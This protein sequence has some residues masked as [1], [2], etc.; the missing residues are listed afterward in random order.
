MYEEGNGGWRKVER[1]NKR[2]GGPSRWHIAGSGVGRF[3]GLTTSF[4]ITEFNDNWKAK[5]LYFEL[6]DLG[7]L[8]EVIISPRKDIR[9]RRFGFS[10]FSIVK[11][12]KFLANRLDNM[13]LEGRKLYANLPRFQRPR[14]KVGNILK[15]ESRFEGK[16][17]ENGER[18]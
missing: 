11:Y 8:V 15:K 18:I 16:E 5:D 17:G 4:F 1:R 12:E 6:K 2:L 10:H 7:D 3:E 13:I 14:R 9:G